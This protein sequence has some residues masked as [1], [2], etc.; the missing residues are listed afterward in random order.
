MNVYHLLITMH[1]YQIVVSCFT[2][3]ADSVSL[4]DFN[5]YVHTRTCILNHWN[6]TTCNKTGLLFQIVETLQYPN[7][8]I[9]LELQYKS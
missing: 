5:I 7:E 2:Y 3:N 4:K 1:G 9:R 8:T 6:K